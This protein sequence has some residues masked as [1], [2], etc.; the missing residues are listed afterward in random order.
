M[1]PS[2]TPRVQT[3][4]RRAALDC[5]LSF[6]AGL[7]ASIVRASIESCS[8]DLPKRPSVTIPNGPRRCAACAC[9]SCVEPRP[10]LGR[11]SRAAQGSAPSLAQAS[12]HAAV[13]ATPVSQPAHARHRGIANLLRPVPANTPPP[14][15][16]MA[17]TRPPRSGTYP[18]GSSPSIGCAIGQQCEQN[19]CTVKFLC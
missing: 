6:S 10:E 16:A 19:P 15:V 17:T 3:S 18:V 7:F 12:P 4:A 11:C 1:T 14:G 5:A 2:T 8:L 13:R 9:A